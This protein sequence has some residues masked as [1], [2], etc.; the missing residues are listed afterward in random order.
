M[1]MSILSMEDFLQI[2]PQHTICFFWDENLTAENEVTVNCPAP[3]VTM[4]NEY[5]FLVLS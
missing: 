4:S 2:D 5:P 1:G 3:Y